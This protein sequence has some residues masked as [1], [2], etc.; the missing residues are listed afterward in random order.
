MFLRCLVI[1]NDFER[2]E[3]FPRELAEKNIE[4]RSA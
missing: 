3:L 4:F 1:E 2:S